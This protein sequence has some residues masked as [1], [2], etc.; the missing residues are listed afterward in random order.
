MQYIEVKIYVSPAGL[1][2]LTALLLAHGVAGVAIDD[3]RDIAAL[4]ARKTGL[5]WDCFDEELLAKGNAC[6]EEIVVSFYLEPGDEGARRLDAIKLDLMK[7]KGNELDG[8]FGEDLPLGRLYAESALRSDEEWKDAWKQYFKPFR[9]TERLSVKP[10]FED[11]APEAPDELVIELDPGMAF[12]TG[13]HETTAL[14]ARLLETSVGPGASVLDVGCGSGI[15]SIAAALLGAG[16]VLGVDLDDTALKVARANIAANGCE[17]RARVTKG[18]LLAGLSFK[19]DVVVAN[20]T[21]ELIAALAGGL[22]AHM[23]P[24]A[25]FIASG[26][27]TERRALAV[28]AIEAAGFRVAESAEAGD[29]CAFKAV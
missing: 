9:M 21:A 28:S 14:C 25:C 24:G 23:K 27:L 19:A 12:G 18:D 20:L 13:L 22:R 10:S 15:L 2:P 11:Y 8:G 1:E 17:S 16:E 4:A 7:L 26:I 29:W 6:A 3:P 5:D